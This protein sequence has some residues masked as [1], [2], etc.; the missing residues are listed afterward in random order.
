[1]EEAKICS[2]CGRPYIGFGNNA[3]PVNNER[4]CDSCNINIVVPR[5]IMD[6]KVSK[7]LKEGGSLNEIARELSN[8]Q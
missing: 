1:M 5:R 7:Y 6:V 2:I 3:Q 4:C 8:M